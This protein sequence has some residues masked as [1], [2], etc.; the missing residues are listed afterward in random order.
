MAKFSKGRLIKNSKNL[1]SKSEKVTKVV[2]EGIGSI[3]DIILENRYSLFL[4]KFKKSDI[5]MRLSQSNSMFFTAFPRYALEGIGILII[6]LISCYLVI[7]GNAEENVIGILGVIALGSQRLLPSFQLVYNG[8]SSMKSYSSSFNCLIEVLK[9]KNLNLISYENLDQIQFNN[10]IELKELCFN[11]PSKNENVIENLNLSFNKGDRI[12]IFGETGSGKSTLLDIL[13]GLLS[14]NSGSFFVDNINLL[15]S[16]NTSRINNF[17]K[18]ISYVPQNSYLIDG[19]F[20][21]NIA[22]GLKDRDIDMD[23]VRNSAHIA[24]IDS[25]IEKTKFS[26]ET[27]VGERGV[28]LS[29]GQRQRIAIARAIYK[30]K[31]ILILDEATSALDN[32]TEKLVMNNIYKKNK[33][34]TIINIAHRLNTLEDCNKIFIMENGTLKKVNAKKFNELNSF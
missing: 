31:M 16:E 33:N 13:T 18:L 14:P 7:F 25:F 26:Y 20:K 4:D 9:T 17:Q 24:K 8:W 32:N 5:S 1:T 34:I 21:S 29:G 11:Y 27:K 28:L 22:F 6:A 19:S 3:R 15:S 30:G 10:K 12:G 2:S 23:R